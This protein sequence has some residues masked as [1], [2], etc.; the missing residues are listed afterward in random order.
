[1]ANCSRRVLTQSL[2]KQISCC[3]LNVECMGGVLYSG[4]RNYLKIG[5]QV[6]GGV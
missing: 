5:G 2:L 1:M 6:Q 3:A 4:D